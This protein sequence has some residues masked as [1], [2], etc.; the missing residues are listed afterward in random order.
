M[1]EKIIKVEPIN[2]T[3]SITWNLGL[4]CNFDCMYCPSYYHNL[5]DADKKLE[6]LQRI[7][8]SIVDKTQH[9]GL[10][11]KIA[12]TGGEVTI[13]K[14]FLPFVEWLDSNYQ[15]LIA[16]IGV[17]TNGSATKDYYHKLISI[18]SIKH[19]SFSTHS[20]YFNERKFFEIIGSLDKE[21]KLLGKTIHVNIMDE[22]WNNHQAYIEF[23]TRR[24]INYSVNEIDYSDKIREE[25]RVNTSNQRY[26]FDEQ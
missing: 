18:N 17:T 3:F 20:E 23:L 5:S 22:Y 25:P 14:D 21:A 2:P 16:E 13:N 12:F 7:W 10:L 1:I 15:N 26:N 19:L 24:N 8:L 9:K 4:R 6:Q 11:Y